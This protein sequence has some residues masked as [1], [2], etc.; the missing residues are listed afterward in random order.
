MNTFFFFPA[1]WFFYQEVIIPYLGEILAFTTAITWA[2]AV[3]L[4]KKSGETVHPIALNL[5][6]NLLAMILFLPT[7]WIF[8]ETLLLRASTSDYLLL[9]F[10]GALGI[11]IADTLFFKSL[12]MLGA[13]MTAI[14]DCLYSPSI[15]GMSLLFL[16]ESLTAIQVVGVIMIISAVLTSA[17]PRRAGGLSRHNLIWGIFWG[18]MAMM[19]MAVGIVIIKPLLERS[20]LLWV[21][22]LRLLGGFL[23][24]VLIL[25]F[26]P[27]RHRIISSIHSVG[28]WYYTLSGSFVGAYLSMVLWLA[29]MKYTQASTA[30]ALNQT[31]NIFIFIFAAIFLKERINLQRA[32]AII[33][34]VAGVLVV[35]FG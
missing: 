33:I 2:F 26:H 32:V 18:A 13:G 9:V 35:T 30:A 12:N 24:L 23:A 6:K 4:F 29:G 27:G 14:L 16:G 5:F 7:M 1:F 10:S 20:P 17:H 11:G 3:I 19:T 28:S 22:E 31:S 21:T 8:G 34:A 25:L 15:I